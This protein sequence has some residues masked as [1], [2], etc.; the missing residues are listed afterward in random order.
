MVCSRVASFGLAK[1]LSQKF[2][3]TAREKR[4]KGKCANLARLAQKLTSKS[5][6]ISPRLIPILSAV[7]WA[8]GFLLV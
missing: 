1:I 2:L 7:R 4:E 3:S 5:G 6:T 8:E